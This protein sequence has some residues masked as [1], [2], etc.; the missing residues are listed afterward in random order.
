VVRGGGLTVSVDFSRLGAMSQIAS[1][2]AGTVHRLTS[3]RLPGYPG[4]VAFKDVHPVG[5]TFPDGVRR[6][7]IRAMEAAVAVRDGLP[8]PDRDLLDE[9]TTWPLSTVELNGATVGILMPLLPDDFFVTTKP[10]SGAGKRKVFELA[11]LSPTDDWARINGIDRTPMTDPLVRLSLNAQLTFV[12]GLLHKHGIVYGDLSLKNVAVAANPPRMRLLDCDATALV[13]DSGRDK[14][15]HSPTFKPPEIENGSKQLQD[16]ETDAYKLGLCILRSMITGPGVTQLKDASELTR[17]NALDPTG[18]DLVT[19]A[20]SAVPADRPTAKELSLYLERTVRARANPPQI[21]AATVSRSALLRGTDLQ[22]T[23][24]VDGATAVRILGPNGLCI[25][26]APGQTSPWTI[27]PPASGDIVVEATNRYGTEQLSAGH[28][29]LYDLPPFVTPAL[30]RPQVP[31]VP[32]VRVP[33]LSSPPP[34]RPLTT[35][36]HPVPR[37]PAPD[38]SGLLGAAGPILP[39]DTFL[40]PGR[41]A[42]TRLQDVQHEASAQLA[43]L[44]TEALTSATT[45][46]R[47]AAATTSKGGRP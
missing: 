34:P 41:R 8:P 26:L 4:E 16:L 14:Q 25:D 21:H 19:R 47:A 12:I 3:Y 7:A 32:A 17:T 23:W 22:V 37:L 29:S 27:T 39:A 43:G 5:P 15:M 35:A 6:Q 18:V 9:F 40:A 36:L 38:M 11:F 2:G 13:A 31:G 1:G 45:A 30:P 10:P 33:A 28:V 24:S 46:V 42:A 20:L 44:I